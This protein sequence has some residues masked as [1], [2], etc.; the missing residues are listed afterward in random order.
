MEMTNNQSRPYFVLVLCFVLITPGPSLAQLPGYGE[1]DQASYSEAAAASAPMS[2][3]DML[4]MSVPGNPGQVRDSEEGMKGR[5]KGH[6]FRITP[7]MLRSRTPASAVMAQTGQRAD[8][9]RTWRP[10]A[11]PSTCAA[12]TATPGASLSTA[13]S[14]P[15]GPSS[16]RKVKRSLK[17]A[18]SLW[19]PISAKFCL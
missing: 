2:G 5:S 13:S 12:W 10:S 3:I 19:F 15:T 11:S 9:T 1:A 8:T 17:F 4:R 16:I 18:K 14:A 6:V 7:S